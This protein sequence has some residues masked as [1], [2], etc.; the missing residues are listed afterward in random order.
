MQHDHYFGPATQQKKVA[1]QLY[2]RIFDLPLVCPH[3]HVDP[4]LFADPD[5]TF[6]SPT[7]LF[8]TPDHYILRMLYSQGISM[9]E[10]GILRLDGGNVQ[11]DQRAIWRLFCAN[12]H[13]FRGTPSGIW[14]AHELSEVFGLNEKPCTANADR[15]YDA[16]SE[17]LAQPEFTPRALFKRFNIE[18]LS[19]TDAATDTLEHHQAIR[20]SG[21]DGRILPTFRPDALVNLDTPGWRAN[22]DQ[23][24]AVSGID[25]VDFTSYTR[26]LEQRR[27][28][29]KS[30][31][32]TATDHAALTPATAE[33]S[34]T[35]TEEI[36]QRALHGETT[37]NDTARFTAHMLIE[38]A[39]MSI[40]DGLVMQLHSGALRNHNRMIFERFGPDK[41][42]DIPL[43]AEY[44]RNLLPLLNKFGNDSRLTLIVFSL[45]ETSYSR[46][47]APL[48]GHYPALK[49]GPPWWFH[50]SPNGMA[51]YFDQIMETAGI[52]NTV[53]FNDDTRAF[54]SIPIRHDLWRR[55]S[56]NWVAGLVVRHLIDM[57]DAHEM[58]FELSV[59]LARRAYRL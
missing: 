51:R 56:A 30:M 42:A 44:T 10:L 41:G 26:A 36:F 55:V 27:E 40:E 24:S 7:E 16:I 2:E 4:R 37:C 59:G 31:G 52:Y 21:W 29:F 3:G 6:G 23:L 32:A 22:I 38:M 46:E 58:M 20:A 35:E 57:D 39:R 48:A 5:A 54:C 19:T 17:K 28:Y 43:Q 15:L 13:L 1:R 33:L 47:L 49:L 45:D 50:D 8:I 53:G 14:L 9:E 25:V 12:F 18:V 34:P 11:T